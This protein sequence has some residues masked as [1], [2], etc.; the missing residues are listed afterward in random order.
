MII[1]CDALVIGGGIHGCA[2]AFHLARR[3]MSVHL[4]E[5]DVTGR[6][7]S[8]VNAGSIHHI[9]RLTPELPLAELALD[10]WPGLADLLDADTGYRRTGHLKLA[11]TDEE[12]EHLHRLMADTAAAC[13]INEEYLDASG[14]ADLEPFLSS[15]CR[16]GVYAPDCGIGNP[17]QT[18]MAFRRAAEG[19]GAAFHDATELRALI[20]RG[21]AWQAETDRGTF[22]APCL[23]NCA[24]AWGGDIAAMLGEAVPLTALPLIMTILAPTRP[25]MNTVIATASQ[26]ISIK[27][28][29]NGTIAIGGGYRGSLD[30]AARRAQPKPASLAYNLKVAMGLYPDFADLSVV[31]TWAGIEGRSPDGLPVIGP[32]RLHEGVWHAFGHSAHGFYLGPASGRLVA[33]GLVTG[34]RHPALAPMGIDRFTTG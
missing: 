24:G 13:T 30:M 22:H 10:D 6:H 17:A 3:G 2:T 18:V 1:Q 33:D 19:L 29:A 11:E 32:S 26:I 12:T 14:V 21:T 27:Q 23:V 20:R 5:R 25:I 8:G 15:H 4:V 28:F 31:R 9:A 7:A 34:H 16:G